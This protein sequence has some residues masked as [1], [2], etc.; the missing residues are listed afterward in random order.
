MTRQILGVHIGHDASACLLREGVIVAAAEEERFNRVKHSAWIP[1]PVGAINFCLEHGRISMNDLECM[2]LTHVDA[3]SYAFK[4]NLNHLLSGFFVNK[5]RHCLGVLISCVQRWRNHYPRNLLT[6][7]SRAL[8]PLRH[9]EHHYAHAASAYFC[10]GFSKA[11]VITADD[12]GEDAST[13]LNVGEAG[14]IKRIKQFSYPNSLG[15]F[16]GGFTEYL[17]YVAGDGENKVMGLASYGDPKVYRKQFDRVLQVNKD[18]YKFDSEYIMV[19][20]KPPQKIPIRHYGNDFVMY[21]Q[22][23]LDIFGDPCPS[24]SDLE[25]EKRYQNIAAGVQNK[26]EEAGIGLTNML[27]EATHGDLGKLCLAG[28]IAL[29]CVMN[30]R[31]WSETEIDD[32][33]IQ[34]LAHDAGTAIGA[35]FQAYHDLGYE[36][37]FTMEHCYYGPEFSNDQVAS[38][39]KIENLKAEFYDDIE[40]VTA[41]LLAKNS[42]IGWFQGRMEIGPR[43]LGN[44][45]ILMSPLRAENKDII[46]QKVKHRENYRPLCPS[47]LAEAAEEYFYDARSSPFMI[48][49][50]KVKEEKRKE[51]PAVVH[52]DG[53]ARPQTVEKHVNPRFHRLIKC[54]ESITGVPVLLNT[55]FNLKGEPIVCTPKDAVNDFAKSKMDCLVMGNYLVS[56]EQSA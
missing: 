11:M 33:F 34:P 41:E 50:L 16:Y 49:A 7:V 36:S 15:S 17:G 4:V 35:A 25:A 2:A 3:F 19:R 26:L 28:G 44:R 32:L 53:T 24:V 47:L 56:K 30:G 12:R 46:N 37:S 8:P 54:F 40:T 6:Q 18:G 52:V 22:K 42:I 31:I 23:M 55:S 48:L 9:I 45:S 29:N 13:T 10:S 1:L 20:G 38:Y 27:I 39:I 51:I 43:A 21:S 14:K 5:P